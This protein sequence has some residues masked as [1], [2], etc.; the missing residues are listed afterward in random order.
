M[1][2]KIFLIKAFIIVNL[3]SFD[4]YEILVNL[5]KLIKEKNLPFEVKITNVLLQMEMDKKRFK[6]S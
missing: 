2:V 4:N 3:F 6:I 1:N 5:K